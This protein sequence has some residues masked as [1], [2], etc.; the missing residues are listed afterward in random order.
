MALSGTFTGTTSNA[1]I[2]PKIV[3]SGEQ[4][5]SDNYTTVTAT[6]YYSRTDSYT[7]SGTW[8]GSIVINGKA[9]NASKSITIKYNSNTMAVTATV[10]IP[11]NDD[12]TKSITISSI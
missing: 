1:A 6:L 12:G 4:S 9:T 5:H 3:W 11:H 10:Q 2:V 7:T 8:N